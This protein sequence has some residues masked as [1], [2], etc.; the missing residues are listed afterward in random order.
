MIRLKVKEI[1]KAK[2]ISQGEFQRR[3]GID[4][5]TA[6]RIFRGQANITLDTLDRIAT[7]L[8][9]HPCELLDYSPPAQDSKQSL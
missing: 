4:M 9:C 1:A 2:H 8:Q 7:A 3:A 5:T 6:R